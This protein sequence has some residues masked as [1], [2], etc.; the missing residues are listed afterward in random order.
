MHKVILKSIMYYWRS[1]LSIIV[2]LVL[3]GLAFIYTF[4]T[5]EH[6]KVQATEQLTKNWRTGYDLLIRPKT[7]EM[8]HKINLRETGENSN[9][10]LDGLVRRGDLAQHHSGITREQYERIKALDG[11]EVAA[12]LTF[13]GNVENEG[14]SI[15][16][17]IKDFGFYYREESTKVFD[18]NRYRDITPDFLADLSYSQFLS[19]EEEHLFERFEDIWELGRWNLSSEPPNSVLRTDGST[20][21]MVAVDPDEEAKL[22][23]LDKAIVEGD[24]F[25]GHH[26][27][28]KREDIPIIPLI[29]LNQ[30]Y[31]TLYQSTIYKIDVPEK[32]LDVDRLIEAGGKEYL[33]SRPR[34]KVVDIN[35]NPF[36]EAYLF[37]IGSIKLENGK[38]INNESHPGFSNQRTILDFSPLQYRHLDQELING[39]PVVEAI[40]QSTRKEQINY[41]QAE[42]VNLSK[43]FSF[44]I[45]GRFD[46]TRLENHFTT[47]DK[48]VSPDYYQP[49]DVYVT[50]D[51]K[52]TKL[53]APYVYQSSPYKDSYYTG[54]IDAITTLAA[55]EYLLG[56]KPIS[57]IRVIVEGAGERSPESMAKVEHIAEK[58]RQETNLHVD[59]MLGSADRKVHVLLDDFDGVPGYGYLLEGWSEEGASFVIEERVS[60]TTLLLTI[61]IVA[62]GL[63][64]L[65]LIYR[66]YTE[67]RK[68]DMTIQYTFGW[69][70]WRIIQSLIFESIGILFL[71]TICFITLY[72]TIGTA[73]NTTQML[74]AMIVSLL[75]SLFAMIC[76]YIIPV[77][78]HLDRHINLRGSNQTKKTILSQRPSNTLWSYSFRNM[79]RHP[80]RS[81]TKAVIIIATL[82]YVSLFLLSKQQA[83]ALLVLTFLGERVDVS[84]QAHQW[85]LF[86]IGILLALFSYIAIHINQ[87][88]ARIGEIQLYKAWGWET[89]RWA[90]LYL[91]EEFFISGAAVSV[92]AICGYLFLT[93]FS[94]SV[95]LNITDVIVFIA[96]SLCVSLFISVV[97]LLL[98]SNRYRL[99]EFH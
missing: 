20:W 81:M 37:N 96:I 25:D 28:Q 3:I 65:S 66:N 7:E 53:A 58:I 82:L 14:L 51:T 13:I 67:N 97:T 34:E 19:N 40:P 9:T 6:M 24:F 42:S 48:P 60:S 22:L 32:Y 18:G 38:I 44:D 63:I 94:D 76:L 11:V 90:F 49:E 8:A 16:F 79:I 10:V 41:R 89:K 92:G 35:F 30:P 64:G 88:E 52:G 95:V 36:S 72:I 43:H 4:Q 62:M 71:V 80:I 46:A 78:R 31:D 27:I 68:R 1:T 61:F 93:S 85:L 56:D 99:R 69:S 17:G 77:I 75:L 21:S 5:S 54:G 15:D 39:V 87:T 84:L 50:H 91:L 26:T 59:I 74:V 83:S 55:A 23:N 33:A 29:L 70:K 12:P 45:I 2:I 47:S 57:I 73:W 86:T 98:R